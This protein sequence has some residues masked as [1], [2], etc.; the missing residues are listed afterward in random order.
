MRGKR[1]NSHAEEFQ[2]VLYRHPPF[3]VGK[4]NI[5][6]LRCEL[7]TGSSSKKAQCDKDQEWAV[8]LQWRN[9]T[10]TASVR[11]SRSTSTLISHIISMSL[12]LMWWVWH[13]SS[14]VFHLQTYNLSLVM[15]KTQTN[16]N[17]GAFY[18]T[19]NKHSSKLLKSLKTRKVGKTVTAKKSQV[20]MTTDYSVVSKMESWTKKGTL[21]KN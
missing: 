5:P 19:Y 3:K 21:G 16:P 7:Y 13:F 10:N 9:L 14:V 12:D 4:H 18:K 17:W 15:R 11:L 6:L 20:D 2:I 8:T 1:Q